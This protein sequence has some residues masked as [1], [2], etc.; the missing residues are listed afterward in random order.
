MT[1]SAKSRALL[2]CSGLALCFSLFS[3]RL[4]HLQVFRHDYYERLATENH[5]A[6]QT[7]P[8]RR[9]MIRDVNGE[10]VAANEPLRTVVADGTLIKPGRQAETARLVADA[11]KIDAAELEQKITTDRRYVVLK[12]EVPEAVADKLRDALRARS[13]RGIAFEEGLRRVYPNGPMLCHVLG[14]TDVENKG[15]QGVEQTMDEFLCGSEGFRFI[16][17]DRKGRE[18]VMFRGQE[19]APHDGC[20]VRLTVD[21]NLQNIVETELDAAVKQYKP[22]GAVVIMMRPQTGEILALANRPCFDLNEINAAQPEQ[23]RDSAIISMVE[24]GST[25]K[26]VTI[27]GAI[28]EREAALDSVVFCENG[29]FNYGG[30]TLHDHHG[31]GELTVEDI[32]AKSSNIGA[33]KLALRLGDQR[34]YDYVRRFG[35]GERTGV[36]LPGEISGVIHPPYRWSKISITRIP[37]GQEVGV[38]PLQVITA[39][40]AIANG[41]RLMMPQIIEDVTDSDGNVVRKFDP[42]EVRRVVSE[43]T[44]AQI[45]RALAKVVSSKGTA[46][47]AGVP[48]FTVA[49]KTGTAQKA[50]PKGGYAPGK[51]VVTFVGFMPAEHPR[52]ACLVMLDDAKTTSE[53]NYGGMIAAPV[54]RQIAEKTARYMNLQPDAPVTANGPALTQTKMEPDADQ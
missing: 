25:F 37:M 8:A 31:Y 19:R 38:T 40:S 29:H 32:L 11:L 50:D 6:R 10:I 24:P 49:G 45:R 9:G 30:R 15:V 3:I 1:G 33:A 5:G 7:I 39:M 22:A 23:M 42:T 4:V 54:F 27:A 35:F 48:G 21:L 17:R 34:L 20:G 53:M 2:A 14:F 46:A 51:Y 18:L 41:G 13:L 44:S 43:D 47:L 28:N 12:K 36:A 26:I 16:E 52:F